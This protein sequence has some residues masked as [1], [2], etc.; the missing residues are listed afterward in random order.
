MVGEA[1][2]TAT[3]GGIIVTTPGGGTKVVQQSRP[4]QPRDPGRARFVRGGRGRRPDDTKK[5]EEEAKRLELQRQAEIKFRERAIQQERARILKL[6]QSLTKRR[7]KKRVQNLRD[8]TTRDRIRL[9]TLTDSKTKERIFTR[10]NLDTGQITTTTFERGKG[11]RLTRSGGIEEGKIKEP[12]EDPKLFSESKLTSFINKFVAGDVKKVPTSG[13]ERELFLISTA[14]TKAKADKAKAKT[15][16]QKLKAQ[17]K[18]SALAFK[19]SIVVLGASVVQLAKGT[20]KVIK[21]PEIAIKGTQR[22]INA[23]NKDPSLVV[24]TPVNILKSI[25]KGINKGIIFAR[26]NPEVAIGRVAGEVVIFIAANQALRLI[27]KGVKA[28]SIKAV[29]GGKFFIKTASGK[30]LPFTTKSFKKSATKLIKPLPPSKVK[31]IKIKPRAKKE[32]LVNLISRRFEKSLSPV[33]GIRVK[34]NTVQKDILKSRIRRQLNLRLKDDDSLKNIIRVSRSKKILR[35]ITRSATRTKKGIKKIFLAKKKKRPKVIDLRQLEAEARS[36]QLEALT[37]NLVN[38][39]ERG[40][41]PVKGIKVTLNAQQRELLRKNIRKKLQSRIKDD[42]TIFNVKDLRKR[43]GVLKRIIKSFRKQFKI[44]KPKKVKRKVIDIRQAQARARTVSI[45]KKAEREILKFERTLAPKGV[46]VKLNIF[47][48]DK[49][50]QRLIDRDLDIL[51]KRELKQKIKIGKVTKSISNLKRSLRKQFRTQKRRKVKRR[52]LDIRQAQ[53]QATTLALQR[54]VK[55][56]STKFEQVSQIKL[57]TAKKELFEKGILKKLEQGVSPKKLLR[58]LNTSVPKRVVKK[59]IKTIKDF[60]TQITADTQQLRSGQQVLLQKTKTIQK[61]KRLGQRQRRALKKKQKGKLT[62]R[63]KQQFQQQQVQFQKSESKLRQELRQTTQQIQKTRTRLR[64]G[65]LLLRSGQDQTFKQIQKQISKL[66][67]PQVTKLVTKTVTDTAQK[68][69][70]RLRLKQKTRTK[71]KTRLKTIQRKKLKGRELLPRVK[72]RRPKR[73]VKP[74]RKNQAFNVKARPIKKRKSQKR[75]RLIRINKVKLNRQ[76]AI[77]LRNEVLDT[78][79]ART[80]SIKPTKGK[81][82]KPVLRT[83]LKNRSKKFR[84]FRIVKGKR[85]PL[86]RGKVIEKRGRLLDT[87]QERRKIT[88]R[89]RIKQITPKKKK[90][91]KV[92]KNQPKRNVS[93]ARR[94]QQLANLAKARKIKAQIASG[95]RQATASAQRTTKKRR[96]ISIV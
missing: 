93:S 73:K 83:S 74:F 28:G 68:Q 42:N 8:K 40:L 88:L 17:G 53:A 9:T 90:K 25:D 59:R 37:N 89:R 44:K 49:L 52:V 62:Q 46:K 63:Q 3:G 33:K 10:E 43:K 47:E 95:A 67:Q 87:P 21:K 72:K 86:R 39:F 91:R 70:L 65:L 64:S 19:T 80:G 54:N 79:L 55:R 26:K 60:Q 32:D 6:Q 57:G 77:R 36:K 4:D 27:S 1:V 24:K 13:V 96:I 20:F 84:N 14:I 75:P 7:A 2:G 56:L 5:R 71:I 16:L 23:I 29:G 38:R 34:L 76:D 82:R 94:R 35:S 66:A 15:D 31:G 22:F 85:I 41:V 92:V 11:G 69:K 78:S 81:P 48:R 12:K 51:E 58:I 30:L 50:K 61:K 18:I 45:E